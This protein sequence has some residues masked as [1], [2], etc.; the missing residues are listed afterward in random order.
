MDK[1]ERRRELERA[2]YHADPEK[3]RLRVKAKYE[4]NAE[5]LRE[6]RRATYAANPES[7]R[8]IAKVRSAEWRLK[9]PQHEGTKLAKKEW[10]LS[11]PGKVRADTIR[12]RVAKMHRT[13][14]WLDEEDYW[15]IE[16]AYELA[17]LRTKLFGFS[18]HVDHILP[19][20]GK[21]VSGLHVPT[22]LQVISG[23]ENVKKSN[24]HLPA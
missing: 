16:Q 21:L 1:K 22:N 7:E 19:L 24:K 20:Q 9:N 3:T 10:K 4:K 8:A 2:R 18:W 6:K 12:R 14:V 23:I 11:N 13:P 15:L 5:K 17:Q